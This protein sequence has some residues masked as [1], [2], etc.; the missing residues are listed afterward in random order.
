MCTSISLLL[1]Y[2]HIEAGCGLIMPTKKS[3]FHESPQTRL[4]MFFYHPA[5]ASTILLDDS[6]FRTPRARP[7][8]SAKITASI[9]KT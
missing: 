5:A 6:V 2:S 1:Y 3:I 7:Q 9:L 8:R 4:G